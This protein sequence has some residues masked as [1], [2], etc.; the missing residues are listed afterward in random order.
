VIIAKSSILLA[1]V[2]FLLFSFI[3]TAECQSATQLSPA[4]L[5]KAVIHTELNTP[6]SAAVHWKYRLEKEVDGTQETREVVETKSGSLDRLIAIGGKPLNGDQQRDETERILRLSHNPEEQQKLEAARQKDAQQ[7][8]RFLQMIPDAFLFEYAGISDRLVRIKFRPNPQFQPPSREA[9]VLHDMAG[10]MW[11]DSKQQRLASI[12][13]QLLDEVKFAKGFLGHLEKG[14]RFIVK[15]AEIAPSQWEVTEMTVN[16]QGK[17]LLLKT[18]SVQQKEVHTDF[19][20]VSEDL[21][22]SEAARILLQQT[23]V[24]VNR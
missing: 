14:G 11:V 6:D 17:V 18:I 5:V 12:D 4:D 23:L 16:M 19:Q 10:E 1:S 24:A 21:S 20:L 2:P 8:N 15:R 22:L 9:K 13:G 7:C 3:R